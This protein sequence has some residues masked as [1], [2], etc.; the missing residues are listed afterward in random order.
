M[1]RLQKLTNIER[2]VAGSSESKWNNGKE[3]DREHYYQQQF[4]SSWKYIRQSTKQA[5]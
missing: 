5:A 2:N 3:T 4:H 1:F